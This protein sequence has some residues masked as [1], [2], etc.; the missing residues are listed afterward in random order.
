MA[1]SDS[2]PSAVWLPTK[3]QFF[4]ALAA[5]FGLQLISRTLL[6]PSAHLDESEQLVFTQQW[7]WG[8]GPQPPLYT[9]IQKL[10]FNAFG[11]SIFSLALLKNLLLFATYALAYWNARF[12][13]R[14]HVCGVAAA[15]LIFIPQISWEAQRDLTHSVMACVFALAALGLF[16]R[17]LEF[18]KTTNHLALGLCLGLGALSKYN[19][20]LFA[21]GL[22]IAA[23]SLKTLRPAV[24]NG[25]MLLALALAVLIFL[26]HGWWMIHHWQ[27]ASSTS[28]KLAI[29]SDAPWLKTTARGLANLLVASGGFILPAAL[30]LGLFFFRAKKTSPDVY[31]ETSIRCDFARLITRTIASIFGLLVLCV[32]IIHVTDFRGRWFQPILLGVPILIVTWLHQRLEPRRLKWLMVSAAGVAIVLLIAMPARIVFGEKLR[33][34]EP[35]NFP[36][37]VLAE[38]MKPDLAPETIIVTQDHLLAG[39]LRL[40]LQPRLVVSTELAA[41]FAPKAS[42][43]ALAWS[44]EKSATPPPALVD[45]AAKMGSPQWEQAK[46]ISANLY[47]IP[48]KR[49]TIGYILMDR[50]AEKSP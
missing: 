3:I 1:S 50:P 24:L 22:F 35:V 41:E 28:H 34:Q 31:G 40:A 49:L 45:Y 39:N 38:Q 7:A 48:S 46:F 2:S 9:W 47:F 29:Q 33:H 37:A 20:I 26:P 27:M 13:T 14:R 18:G 5:Y 4:L 6:S 21:A 12:I 36:F 42:H 43:V 15:A 10:F 25:R 44:L 23:L 30:A 32:M 8:Y 17:V 16:C 11:V 19:F